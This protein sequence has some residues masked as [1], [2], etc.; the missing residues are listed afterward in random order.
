MANESYKKW[1]AFGI[2][3][4]S[5][6]V[7]IVSVITNAPERGQSSRGTARGPAM[8][9][10]PVLDD[11]SRQIT[12]VEELGID[13]NNPEALA[14]SGD[15]YFEQG[16]YAQAIEIYKKVIELDPGHADTYNDLGLAYFYLRKPDLAIEALKKAT[17]TAPDMQ[18]AWLS[19]GFVLMSIGKT[20]EARP[21]LS[22]A[23]EIS[24]DS[25]V[26]AEAKR[27]LDVINQ[28]PK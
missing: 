14:L 7:I 24:P 21:V 1:I 26:G 17:D 22:K 5:A 12:P 2:I 15:R 13:I 27:M 6:V 16:N 4:L 23:H 9:A 3:F 28:G 11:G 25:M 10:G 19:Y 18:R 20:S 8:S